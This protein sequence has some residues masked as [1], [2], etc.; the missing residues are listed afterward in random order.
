MEIMTK[1]EIQS[2]VRNLISNKCGRIQWTFHSDKKHTKILN[3]LDQ[4]FLKIFWITWNKESKI[5]MIFWE[6]FYI[7][8]NEYTE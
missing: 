1:H 8:N 5:E 2:E 7:C 4:E 3:F 6:T